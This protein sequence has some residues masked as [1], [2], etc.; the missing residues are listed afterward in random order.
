MIPV[1]TNVRFRRVRSAQRQNGLVGFASV[2]VGGVVSVYGI[3][4]RSVGD[5]LSVELPTQRDRHG[6]EH[7]VIEVAPSVRAAIANEII[8]HLRDRGVSA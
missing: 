6:R 3:A 5:R 2:A 8:R 7:P 1:I 4:V